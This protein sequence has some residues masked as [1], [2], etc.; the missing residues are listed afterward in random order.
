MCLD[1]HTFP[2]HSIIYST[3][4]QLNVQGFVHM[5]LTYTC[6]QSVVVYV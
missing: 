1:L 5:D 3:V 2:S 6:I 4:S